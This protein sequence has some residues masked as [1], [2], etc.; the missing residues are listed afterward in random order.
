[1]SLANVR[2]KIEACRRQYNE[3]RPHRALRW[4]MP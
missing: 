4:R 3:S 1:M 2:G